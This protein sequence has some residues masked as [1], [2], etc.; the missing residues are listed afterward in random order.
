M[1]EL[2]RREIGGVHRLMEVMQRNE[3]AVWIE[4]LWRGKLHGGS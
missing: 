2:M 1:H 3:L 4:V